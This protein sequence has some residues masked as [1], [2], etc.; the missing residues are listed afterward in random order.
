MLVRCPQLP[1]VG[2]YYRHINGAPFIQHQPIAQTFQC[3]ARPQCRWAVAAHASGV[4]LGQAQ[5]ESATTYIKGHPLILK[6]ARDGAVERKRLRHISCKITRAGKQPNSVGHM[7]GQIE[8]VGGQ[9]K[10]APGVA[11]QLA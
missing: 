9:Q 1:L 11:G 6:G 4:V 10:C 3:P 7:Q 2:V 5:V 8:I